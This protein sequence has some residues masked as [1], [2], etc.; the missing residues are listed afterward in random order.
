VDTI[1]LYLTAVGEYRAGVAPARIGA[2]LARRLD[3]WGARLPI[4][5]VWSELSDYDC[6]QELAF[7]ADT[8]LPSRSARRHFARR[9]QAK[10]ADLLRLPR[11][12][13]ETGYTF[14]EAA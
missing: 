11:L 3:R 7:L 5:A 2:G 6:R 13:G 4:T 1:V 12:L 8:L 9:L 10:H 14:E